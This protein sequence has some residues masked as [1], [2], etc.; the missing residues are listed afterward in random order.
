LRRR[1]IRTRRLERSA[2]LLAAL[3]LAGCGS[4]TPERRAA[5]RP[6]LPSPLA[7][8]LADRSDKVAAALDAGDSCQALIEAR[9]LQQATIEAINTGRIPGPFQEHLTSTVGDLVARIQCVPPSDDER[10]HG[11][12]KHERGKRKHKEDK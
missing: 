7:G 12:G 1:K 9:R 10:D 5:P 2:A 4:S 6:H 8:P 11:K 3:W